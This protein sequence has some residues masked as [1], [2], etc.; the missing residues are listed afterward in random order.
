MIAACAPAAAAAQAVPAPPPYRLFLMQGGD[1]VV[2]G[3]YV[4]A[5]NRVVF[6]LPLAAQDG[7]RTSQ[8]VTIPAAA[9]D[10]DTTGRYATAVRA[11]RYASASGPADF[12]R[13]STEVARALNDIAFTEEPRARIALAQ[14]TRQRLLDWTEES[15]GYRAEE[16]AE[17][18]ALLDDAVAA[19]TAAAGDLSVS[20]IA[21]TA[22]PRQLPILPV[23]GLQEIIARALTAA[24]LTAVQEERLGILHAVVALLDDPRNRLDDEWRAVN[25]AIAARDLEVEARSA[26]DHA[27]LRRTALAAAAG[28]ARRAD[29]RG[30]RSVLERVRARDTELGGRNPESQAALLAALRGQL[31]DT[32]AL[33]LERD[34]RLH[35]TAAAGA[36]GAGVR[37]AL[38]RFAAARAALDDIRMVTEPPA[39]VLAALERR[40]ASAADELAGHAPPLEVRPSQDLLQQALRLAATAARQRFQAAEDGDPRTVW[41]SAAAAAGALMLFDRAATMLNRAL[42]Q[43]EPN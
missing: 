3:D 23:P 30:V 11:A 41:N 19:D 36:F 40:L 28:Y 1:L 37:I 39:S 43:T 13:M 14:R 12:E 38:E 27:E 20:L 25:R 17:I 24:R 22:R 34:R 8:L 16:V 2:R 35:E 29:V 33:R 31:A 21:T 6:L 9:V 32:R 7:Q 42:P 26:A 10:W 5:G 15:H 18:V 4:R